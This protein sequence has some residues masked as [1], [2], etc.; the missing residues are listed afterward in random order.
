[1]LGLGAAGIAGLGAGRGWPFR[2]HPSDLPGRSRAVTGSAA[3]HRGRLIRGH[4]PRPRRQAAR[5]ERGDHAPRARSVFPVRPGA[6]PLPVRAGPLSR[7]RARI[8]RAHLQGMPVIRSAVV[9]IDRDRRRVVT[10]E[11]A[12]D[13]DYLALTSGIRL[14]HERFPGWPSSPMRTSAR[15]TAPP[16]LLDLRRRIAGFRAGHVLIATPNGPYT[17]PPAPYE[18]SLLWAAHI[19]R[20]R[21]RPGSRWSTRARGRPPGHREG[22]MRAMEAYGGMLTYEPF[23]QV[24]AVDPRARTVETEAGRLS[25]DVLSVI[26]PNRTMP[27]ITDAGLG[28][29]SSTWTRRASGPPGTNGSTRSG[30][31]PTRHTPRTGYT[32]MDSARVAAQSVAGDLG[33]SAPAA[34]LP[35]NVCYPMVAPD[36]RSTSRRTGRWSRTPP[37]PSM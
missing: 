25:Y 21:S 11:G 34:A 37:A 20:Q 35:A 13:Y 36:R 5:P 10:T 33:V 4:Q 24:R 1:M 15:T 29:P 19:K 26:P 22:L 12:V 3:R 6:A 9:A 23:T 27:F 32:A 14:A 28:A 2:A 18:Y 31:T 7:D 30:T 16:R 8:R 17:C